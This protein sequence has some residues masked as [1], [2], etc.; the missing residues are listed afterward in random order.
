MEYVDPSL[1][2]PNILVLLAAVNLGA[3]RA[4]SG[5]GYKL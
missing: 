4:V 1:M 2:K 3:S 5:L